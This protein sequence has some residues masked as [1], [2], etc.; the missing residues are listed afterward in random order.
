[1]PAPSSPGREADLR[2][3]LS[4]AAALAEVKASGVHGWQEIKARDLFIWIAFG[5]R[6]ELGEGEINVYMLPCQA[7]TSR[8]DES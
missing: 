1:M 6:Y 7:V 3:E 2:I 4:G 8:R 5:R